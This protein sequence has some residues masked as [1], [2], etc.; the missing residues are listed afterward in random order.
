MNF[1]Y[2]PTG[3]LYKDLESAYSAKTYKLEIKN[4]KGIIRQKEIIPLK[5][6]RP[7]CGWLESNE[8]EN[9]LDKVAF[10]INKSFKTIDNILCFSYKDLSLAN[11]VKCKNTKID[12]LFSNKKGLF[13][14]HFE[15]MEEQEIF[16]KI[17][18]LKTK[19]DLVII[20]HYLEHFENIEEIMS[21]LR[22]KML[23]KSICFLEVPDCNDFIRNKNP[24]FLWEQHRWYFTYS[25]ILNWLKNFGWEI[26]K[27]YSV[28]YKMEPSLCF[29]IRSSYSSNN[30]KAN[31]IKVSKYNKKKLS[32]KIFD[33]YLKGWENFIKNS[34][35]KFALIGIGH[36]SDRFLQWTN[37]RNN[38]NYLIDDASEKQGMFLAKCKIKITR[39]KEILNQ[40][41]I[42]LLG[43][44]PR[45]SEIIK[46][47]L[48]KK[49][50]LK[51][52][53]SIFNNA[54]E[55]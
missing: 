25:N 34:S 51:N 30:K 18:N 24:M 40:N 16:E 9:H 46:E 19:Y 49:Y 42:V 28:N 33:E 17:S 2:N 10:E 11:R 54:P 32:F 4:E 27:S 12:V 37:S 43:V 36:N 29:F 13:K 35:N 47:N 23:N 20:R 8:P 6:F 41:T 14:E 55:L 39:N 50:N 52:I 15:E 5:I 48:L 3:I 45:N 1:S 7:A 22:S 21:V 53:Y 38:I 31:E 26:L 44:H